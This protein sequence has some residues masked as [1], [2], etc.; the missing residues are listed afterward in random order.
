MNCKRILFI[1]VSVLFPAGTNAQK[2]ITSEKLGKLDGTPIEHL[3]EVNALVFR[4]RGY[5]MVVNPNLPDSLYY[6]A[7]VSK[8]ALTEMREKRIRFN[9]YLV[10][11]SPIELKKGDIFVSFSQAWIRLSSYYKYSGGDESEEEFRKKANKNML[12]KNDYRYGRNAELLEDVKGI[13]KKL[14]NAD[15]I[16]IFEPKSRYK[17][18]DTVEN[19]GS[20]VVHLVKFDLGLVSL[21]Y[22]YPLDRREMALSEINNTWGIIQFKP[23]EEFKH[24]NHEN[25]T[26]PRDPDLY[27]GKFSILNNPEQIKRE[28]EQRGQRK[29]Y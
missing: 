25:G 12:V 27:F 3:D 11:Y 22:F 9:P 14:L 16:F 1:V 29:K 15:T 2:I 10:F 13:P 28:R 7:V 21:R 5:D 17:F 26:P 24:P 6:Q 18:K 8:D 23:D 19:Y 4:P 20:L